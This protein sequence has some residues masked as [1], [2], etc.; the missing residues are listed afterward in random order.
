MFKLIQIVNVE[1]PVTILHHHF[2]SCFLF[3]MILAFNK[4]IDNEHQQ[5]FLDIF[6]WF[7]YTRAVFDAPK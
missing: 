7:V 1:F 5:C 4:C 3:A 2:N 6:Y